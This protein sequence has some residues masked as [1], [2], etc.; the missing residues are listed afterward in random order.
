[1]IKRAAS[2]ETRVFDLGVEA[3]PRDVE[4]HRQR[5]DGPEHPGE[6]REA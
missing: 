5:G 2:I 1:M 6:P 3:E 4:G